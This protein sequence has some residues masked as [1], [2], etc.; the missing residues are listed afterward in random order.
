MRE[1]RAARGAALPPVTPGSL[2]VAAPGLGDPNFSRSVVYMIEHRPRGSLGVVLNRPG[3]AAV[4]DVLPRWA[5][6]TSDPGSMF[7][8]GPVE[9]RTALGLA[10][11]RTGESGRGLQGLMPVRPPV[12]L[13]DLDS[14]PGPLAP[15]LRGLRIF[16]GYSGWDAGQLGGEIA[17]GDWFVVPGLPDDLLTTSHDRLWERVLRR[18]GTPLALL[19][20]FPADPAHN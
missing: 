5:G 11:L 15:R 18:Q 9:N 20:T 14:D 10:A 12:Q 2:L 13:V 3:P 6:L 1:H 19:A 7:V 16:A 4:R 8:G 17:R